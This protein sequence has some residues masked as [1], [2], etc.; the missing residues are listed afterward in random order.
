VV[1]AGV[2]MLVMYFSTFD[3]LQRTLDTY[4]QRQRFADVFAS[5]RRA[6]RRLEER[7]ALLP[8]VAA[9][10]TRVVADVTLDVAGMKEPA[11][12]RLVSVPATAR[13]RLNDVVLRRGRWIASGRTDEVV[14]SEPFADAHKL[15]PGDRVT[16]VINGRRRTLQ[17][18]GLGL[19]PE[20]VYTIPP[21]EMIPDD[22]RFAILWMERRA[23]ASAFDMEGGFNDVVL[24]LSRGASADD[25]T[26]QVDRLLEPYG[27]SRAITRDLQ[28]SHWTLVNELRQIRTFGVIVPLI[29]LGIAA[30][31]LNIALTRALSLQRPQIASLKALGYADSEIGWHYLQWALLIAALGA[32][33]GVALGAWLGSGMITLYNEFFRFPELLYQLSTGVAVAGVGVALG[34]GGLGAVFA[35]RR[36][37]QVPPAEA[38]RPEPPARYRRSFVERPGLQ[39]RLTHATR[40]VLR[41]LERQ[42]ARAAATVVGIAFAVAIL[43]FGFV[44]L[45]V[46]DLLAE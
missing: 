27:G 8:G 35:V 36:A 20:Y 10:E 24:A 22:K 14:A 37:V 17:I 11:V 33:V 40:M 26:A 41:S 44:F 16:A 3:S 45:D 18:V 46:M 5:A 13:P 28:L 4:Y 43:L 15:R 21:G 25:V 12:G 29:F 19:S 7:L 31:L 30:F 1:M 6:P 9:V 39:R 42:P 2:S 38:M 32:L 34:A 23:V